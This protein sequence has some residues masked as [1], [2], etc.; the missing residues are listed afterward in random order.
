MQWLDSKALPRSLHL[1]GFSPL[2]SSGAERASSYIGGSSHILSICRTSCRLEIVDVIQTGSL[3]RPYFQSP[4]AEAGLR[5]LSA[6]LPPP[7]CPRRLA[8]LLPAA[9]THGAWSLQ[10]RAACPKASKRSLWKRSAAQAPAAPL[11]PGAP[12]PAARGVSRPGR[13]G[14]AGRGRASHR[15]HC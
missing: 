5:D 14:S 11:R 9:W 4:S 2:Y 15:L 3:T 12:A 8:A 10:C 1:K 6:G 7:L 13:W